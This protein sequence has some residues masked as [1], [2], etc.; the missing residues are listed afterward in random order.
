MA[1]HDIPIIEQ[2]IAKQTLDKTV[3]NSG[4]KLG[5]G[6]PQVAQVE[7]GRK[8]NG[9]TQVAPL[10]TSGVARND[11]INVNNNINW[12][13]KA[14]QTMQIMC[15]AVNQIYAKDISYDHRQVL[16]VKD[17]IL[18]EGLIVDDQTLNKMKE[19]LLWFREREPMKDVPKHINFY[20]PWLIKQTRSN[21]TKDKIQRLGSILKYK[22]KRNV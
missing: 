12:E 2:E 1:K 11:S 19:A 10:A 4:D 13:S 18:K 7:G 16:V 3:D 20:K 22:S 14:K 21:K 9:N 17:W 15:K 8:G 5:K 6:N